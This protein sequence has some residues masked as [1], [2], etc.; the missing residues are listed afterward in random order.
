MIDNQPWWV[1]K[2]VCDVLDIKNNRQ[3]LE[4]LD[5]DEKGVISSDTPGGIQELLT[6]NEPGLYSLIITSRKKEAKEFKRW[7]THEVIP[8]IRKSGSYSVPQ[9]ALPQSYKEAL[10]ALIE[11]VEENEK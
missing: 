6:V 10:V 3:A 4:R 9:P 1:A 8:S 11:K 5:D 7:I 2:D